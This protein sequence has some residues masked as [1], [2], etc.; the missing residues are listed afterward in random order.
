MSPLLRRRPRPASVV[1][2]TRDGCTLCAEAEPVV[3]RAAAD[4]G[5][6]LEVR[7]VDALPP[8]ERAAWTDHVPVVLVDGRALS[9]WFVDEDRLRRALRG[10]PT[11]W[12]DAG[13]TG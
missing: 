1:L 5:V 6:A 4:A 8:Q 9:Y 12:V 2:V 10:R 7:D 3:A 13:R 11:T